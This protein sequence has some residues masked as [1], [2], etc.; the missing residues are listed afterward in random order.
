MY[1]WCHRYTQ[2]RWNTIAYLFLRRRSNNAWIERPHH[3]AF[4]GYGPSTQQQPQE[5]VRSI[6]STTATVDTEYK[7]FSHKLLTVEQVPQQHT[8]GH[9]DSQRHEP[10]SKSK[11]VFGK[12]FT[13]H[14][15]QIQYSQQQWSEPKIVPYQNLMISPAASSL[16][17]GTY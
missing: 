10:Q 1:R 14:M 5:G 12:Q 13:P 4:R 15:L 3:A 2:Q 7:K 17:Y 6:M 11:L 16:H 8:S 9:N